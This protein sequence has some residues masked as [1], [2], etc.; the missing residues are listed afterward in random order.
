VDFLRGTNGFG[1]SFISDEHKVI[2]F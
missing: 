2:F 1:W